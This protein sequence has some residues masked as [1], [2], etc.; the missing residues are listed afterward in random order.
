MKRPAFAL[1]LLAVLL[2]GTPAAKAADPQGEILLPGQLRE[3]P[4]AAGETH[5]Y[6]VEVTDAPLLVSV[7]QRGIDLVLEA[8]GTADPKPLTSDAPN[9]RWGPEILLLRAPDGYRIEVRPGRRSVPPGRY[10]I[11]VEAVSTATAEGEQRL[12]A[13]KAMSR[14]IQLPAGT[15]ET[16]RQALS[17]YREALA[18]WR[19]L[20]ERRWEA[21]ALQNI[22][23]L[24]RESGDLPASIEDYG[25]ALALWRALSEPSREAAVRRWLGMLHQQAAE[26]GAA[27]EALMAATSL[28]RS[29]GER[30]EEGMSRGE[31]CFLEHTT[32]NPAV[33]LACY[34]EVRAL[35][36]EAGDSSQEPRMLN[37]LGGVYDLLGEP[38]AALESYGQALALRHA[39]GD[40]GGEA[41][42]LNNIAMIHQVL[43]DWQE[44]L[45]IYARLREILP[46]PGDPLQ[47]SSWLN[48]VAFT[49]LSLGEPERALSF[50]EEALT[51]RRQSGARREELITLNN[52]GDARRQLGE[53][54]KALD[55]YQQALKLALAQEDPWQE[56]TTR[57]RLGEIRLEMGNPAAALR[58][59]D[60]AL[61]ALGQKGLRFEELQALQLQARA[62]VLAGRSQEALP[63]MRDVL[64]RRKALGDRAGEAETLRTLAAAERSLG[65]VEEAQSHAEAAVARVEELRTGFVTLSLRAA[66]LASRR[67]AYSLLIDLLMDR[68]AADPGGGH[69][70]AALAVSEQARARSLLDALYTRTGMAGSAV[71][72]AL[73]ARRQSLHRRLSA[74]ANQ[75]QRSGRAEAQEREIAGLL[76]ELDDVEAEIRRADPRYAALSQPQPIGLE[77]IARLLDPGT[78]LLE[79]SLGEE[80]SV[81]WA[82]SSEGLRSF[83]LPS[84]GEIEARARQVYEELRTVE[85]GARRRPETAADLSRI[86]LGP[87][88]SQAVRAR[89]LVVVPD[90]ALHLLP[91]GALP[92]PARGKGWK[93]PAGLRPLLDRLEV[94]YLPSAATLAAQRQRL[95]GRPPAPKWAAVLADPVFSAEDP[96]LAGRPSVANRRPQ[97]SAENAPARGGEELGLLPAHWDRLPSSRG[98]AK[99]IARLAPAGEVWTALDFAA[100]R[101]AVLSADLRAYRVLHFATHGIADARTPELSGLMLSAVD[102]SGRP[103][104]GFLGLSDL[105]GLD[106]AADLVV[107]S[108]CQTGVGKELRGEGLMGITRG[109]LYAGVPRVVASL[110]KVEDRATAELMSLFYRALWR[111]GL[112]PAA[113][114]RSAQQSLRRDPRYRAPHSWAGFV[115]QGD[116]R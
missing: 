19:S 76:V 35:F 17:V 111:Q 83:I 67:R 71:P 107:L 59:I 27:R 116:W 81:L 53:P 112:S 85:I 80:R 113:A 36:R 50:L 15:V 75:L 64:A 3:R 24:E 93:D 47:E 99:A 55:F 87:V 22:A 86:L 4:I 18:A 74:K 12:E 88:W 41:Q 78:L 30:F 109:F 115:L 1:V 108:A 16:R 63:V 65:A 23:A 57:L 94:V 104:E 91:F 58:E 114:L 28:W 21:E 13:L 60:P 77:G 11:E 14:A 98:E 95:E 42:T 9:F 46:S 105:Y 40:R 54:E 2:L 72:A 38:D 102:A 92:A 97:P 90:G 25:K 110:W 26:Y 43:G 10:A 39:L 82:V 7:E 61:R 48:N 62:L 96:R 8:R 79:Y 32:G 100:N 51:L 70:R 66:F 44:A 29:L 6:R 5:V 31:L 33:A 20:G 56:A 103:R 52:L 106:L 34:E 89:R 45:R 37:N 69:D 84:Q 49:Y 73:T 101:D 68:H